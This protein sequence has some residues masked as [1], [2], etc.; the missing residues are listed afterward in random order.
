MTD[1][2]HKQRKGFGKRAAH[3]RPI[4]LGVPFQ[5]TGHFC[6][7]EAPLHFCTLTVTLQNLTAEKFT[8]F[9]TM[10]TTVDEFNSDK[11]KALEEFIFLVFRLIVYCQ[12]Q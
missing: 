1:F 2:G 3:L 11:T 6:I 9:E 4:F 8:R 5:G 12:T 10:I 7:K